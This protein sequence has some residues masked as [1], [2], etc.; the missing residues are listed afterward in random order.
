MM[1][2][3]LGREKCMVTARNN[4]NVARRTEGRSEEM[5]DTNPEMEDLWTET[6]EVSADEHLIGSSIS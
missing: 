1:E 2:E 6:E 4:L 3:K 5:N